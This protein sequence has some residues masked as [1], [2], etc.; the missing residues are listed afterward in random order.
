MKSG[1]REAGQN[2]KCQEVVGKVLRDF[3]VKASCFSPTVPGSLIHGCFMIDVSSKPIT[4]KI[5]KETIP[6]FLIL[7]KILP[8]YF[9]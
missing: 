3:D 2:D 6:C 9:L 5:M 8:C 7:N 4:F 1:K